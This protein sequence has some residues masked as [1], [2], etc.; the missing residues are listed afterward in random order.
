ML[1]PI[2]DI[3]S[4][5]EIGHINIDDGFPLMEY[6]KTRTITLDSNGE[7]QIFVKGAMIQVDKFMT[8]I[9]MGILH[10]LKPDL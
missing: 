7:A 6:L 8:C 2:Y 4:S 9:A 3:Q 5:E 10:G 1:L